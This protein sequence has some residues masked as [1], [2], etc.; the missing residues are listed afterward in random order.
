LLRGIKG[1][2]GVE[3]NTKEAIE[4]ASEQLLTAIIK[5]NQINID[6]VASVFFTTTPDLNAGFPAAAAR[7]LGFS[8]VPL[9]GAV[10][11]SVPGSPPRIIRVVLHVNTS[12]QQREMIHVYLGR[13]RHLRPDLSNGSTVAG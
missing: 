6:D 8:Q 2:I 13:A 7:K 10:E 4:A 5:A 12:K 11:M 1:A 3:A 9:V